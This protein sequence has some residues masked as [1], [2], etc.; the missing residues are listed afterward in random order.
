MLT[1]QAK[2]MNCFIQLD[3]ADNTKVKNLYKAQL[4]VLFYF[5]SPE[6][7]YIQRY[8][9]QQ[10]KD[11]IFKEIVSFPEKKIDTEEFR[12]CERTV[13][14]H[15][16][17]REQAQLEQI[18]KDWD[19]FLDY[20]NSIPWDKEVTEVVKTGK[21]EVVKSYKVS[22]MEERIKAVKTAKDILSL[23]KELEAIV[24]GKKGS[25]EETAR[26]RLFEDPESINLY[27]R[28]AV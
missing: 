7:I 8:T 12:S 10:R 19:R 20:L 21:K 18:Q 23:Q 26:I 25:V 15:T 5:Y 11:L 13:A 22:N 6:S 3:K 1:D 16:L 27:G 14:R 24:A 9:P 4:K 2:E 17:T 28:S